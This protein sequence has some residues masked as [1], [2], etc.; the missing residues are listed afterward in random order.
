MG[1]LAGNADMSDIDRLFWW[2]EHLDY[3]AAFWGVGWC[4]EASA[5]IFPK[6]LERDFNFY[7]Y[8]ITVM[9]RG[10]IEADRY[11]ITIF[12][13]NIWIL[14]RFFC[15]IVVVKK[16][17][18]KVFNGVSNNLILSPMAKCTLKICCFYYSSSVEEERTKKKQWKNIKNCFLTRYSIKL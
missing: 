8:F 12:S 16:I 5:N 14:N 2:T 1:G 13:L 4:V 9:F 17:T 15:G 3:D 7:R 10:G 11:I 18:E 6:T